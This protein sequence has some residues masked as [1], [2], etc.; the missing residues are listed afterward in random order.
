MISS[1]AI[2]ES[3]LV[4]GCC[5][6]FSSSSSSSS[7]SSIQRSSSLMFTL[8]GCMA[9]VSTNQPPH[10]IR[11]NSI[12][13]NCIQQL[14]LDPFLSIKLPGGVWWLITTSH[15]KRKLKFTM[16]VIIIDKCIS[17]IDGVGGR[18][19]GIRSS[20]ILRLNKG[21]GGEVGLCLYV[22]GFGL[23]HS[24]PLHSLV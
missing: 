18:G 19:V 17:S 21:R 24:T 6:H 12:P 1:L 22:S 23:V 4:G 9:H 7:S 14:L 11:S 15:A 13:F 2:I 8:I 3:G 10:Y 16:I 20:T 5:P